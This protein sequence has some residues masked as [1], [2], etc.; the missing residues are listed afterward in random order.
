MKTKK[1]AIID[2][3]Q[4]IVTYLTSALQDTGFE[5]C[6][7]TNANDGFELIRK[8]HPDLICIDILM[9]EETGA[10]LYRRIK[11]DNALK[12]IPVVVVSGLSMEKEMKRLGG[13]GKNSEAR[14]EPDGYIEKPIDLPAFLETVQK[15]TA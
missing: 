3:E 11:S 4:D 1:I 10:S 15:L 9:P 6:S 12:S 7:A 2:D 13:N 14:F 8:H 5:V